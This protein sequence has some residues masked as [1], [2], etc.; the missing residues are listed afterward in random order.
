MAAL[1]AAAESQET[2]IIPVSAGEIVGIEDGVWLEV[3]NPPGLLN[4]QNSN[5]NS[6]AFRL[7]Y[8][9]FSILLTGDTEML[10]E[11]AMLQS[12]R[13]LQSV[14]L[15]AAHH[16]SNTSSTTAFL[17]AVYP[18]VVVISA[19][20]DNRFGHPHPEML[21]RAAEV[22]AV[23]LRTD[24]LGTI[25]VITDGQVMWWQGEGSKVQIRD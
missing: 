11:Q 9:D 8:G 23:I 14:V 18:Q 13:P 25:E 6:V 10:A 16:G 17:T 22:G 4:P 24:Q 15:K 20:Q 12:G 3:L 7:V 1:V 5:Q 19:G 2:P 21:Q